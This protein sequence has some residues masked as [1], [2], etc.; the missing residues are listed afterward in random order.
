MATQINNGT[1]TFTPEELKDFGEII[2]ALVYENEELNAIH[3]VHE[4]VKWD[5]QIVFAGKIGL[6]GKAV[7]GNCAPNEIAGVELTQKFWQ[8]VN[9]DFRLKHCSSDVNS[10]DKLINQMAKMNPDFY[11]VIEGSQST[12]GQFLVAKVLE[13]FIENL[14]RKVWFS[15]KAADT[16]ANGGALTNGTDKEY[17][18]TQDGLWK[19]IVANIPTTDA[20][21]YVAAPRNAGAT[22]ATQELQANDAIGTLR[23]MYNK[24][25]S[26]LR[27]LADKKFLVT[28][29]IYDGYVNDLEDISNAGAGNTLAIEEG[30]T[31][32][33]YRGIEVIMMEVWDRNIES[34]YNNGTIYDK[35]NRAVLST[36]SNLPIATLAASD[37]GEVDAF[38][39]KVSKQ[40]YVDGVYSWDAK[41]LENYLTVVSY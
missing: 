27:N 1:F 37:F 33:R 34:Y 38:Y 13:G 26:R 8:P 14:L 22:Y 29:T 16:I 5:E 35:P 4:G 28:R 39:D 24:A 2:H 32:L 10:Q 36:P 15:D 25:D 3:E 31:V 23:A 19:E 41:H 12:V 7:K 18:N 21:H 30:R 40:N 9:E 17:F 11:D 20:K 6:M